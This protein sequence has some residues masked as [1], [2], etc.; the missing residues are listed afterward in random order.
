MPTLRRMPRVISIDR[1][2]L[3][4]WLQNF[5]ARHGS[6]SPVHH[7]DT[8]VV[9]AEDGAVATVHIPFGPLPP[10]SA[11][12]PARQLLD[13]VATDRRIGA[14]LVRRGG[15]AVGV[16]DGDSLISSKTGSGYVQGRTKA[17]GWSQQRYARRRSNQADQLYAKASAA[18]EAVLLPAVD[19]LVAVAAGGD[20][21]G[22]EAALRPAALAPVRA[23]LLPRVHPTE[24]PRKRVLEG[25]AAT[26]LAVDIEL[27]ELA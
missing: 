26:F 7:A 3:Q 8:V 18:A 27:N 22:V 16:F 2:R 11:K 25:F 20:R 17:G 23:L 4:R 15:F 14:I 10:G 21:V 9:E 19:G 1:R 5:A 6:L 13:H 12:D 24:D